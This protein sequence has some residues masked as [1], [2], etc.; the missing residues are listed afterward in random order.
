MKLTEDNGKQEVASKR[1]ADIFI[2]LKL[3]TSLISLFK[4]LQI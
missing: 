2:F 3:K 1:C 4:S